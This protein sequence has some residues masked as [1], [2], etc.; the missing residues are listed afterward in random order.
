MRT[1]PGFLQSIIA[2]IDTKNWIYKDDGVGGDFTMFNVRESVDSLVTKFRDP[3]EA[4]GASLSSV[5]DEV[6]EI[7]EYSRKFLAISTSSYREIW[8]K[9]HTC[10]DCNRWPNLLL[11]S[12]LVFSLPFSNSRV[13][14]IFSSLGCIKTKRRTNL[15]ITVP[16]LITCLKLSPKVLLCQCSQLMQL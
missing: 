5:Q 9:L 4:K 10:H 14:Q 7:I 8:Y 15:S 13:E 6:E 3:L 2:F 12:E 16:H 1:N 11:L